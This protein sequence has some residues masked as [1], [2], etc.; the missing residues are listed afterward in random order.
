MIII[1]SLPGA[2]DVDG[3]FSVW[4]SW[5]QCS[6]SCGGGVKVRERSC[7]NPPPKGNGQKCSGEFEETG[8]CAEH[9]CPIRKIVKTYIISHS[10]CRLRYWFFTCSQVLFLG[11]VI[12]TDICCFWCP[13]PINSILN[14]K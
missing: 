8:A 9:P 11:G 4:S 5:T 10:C 13:M 7:T 14:K 1:V 3:G 6:K 2:G 12:L